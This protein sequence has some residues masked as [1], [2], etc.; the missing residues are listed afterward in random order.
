MNVSR[1]GAAV[2]GAPAIR[3]SPSNVGRPPG[4]S[5]FATTRAPVFTA[6]ILISVSSLAGA[7]SP[8]SMAAG[9]TPD[10][11]LPQV[12]LKSTSGSSTE[13]WAKK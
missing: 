2:P 9:P 1:I 3:V 11:M 6:W 10:S 5:T 8:I 4:V 13:T 7:T 12:G